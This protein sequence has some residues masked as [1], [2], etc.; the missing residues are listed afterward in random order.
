M[1]ELIN[2]HTN[3]HIVLPTPDNKICKILIKDNTA[4]PIDWSSV[5]LPKVNYTNKL[6]SDNLVSLRPMTYYKGKAFHLNYKY[7]FWGR[8]RWLLNKIKIIFTK[9]INKK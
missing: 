8:L 3:E 1:V 2:K 7:G 9:K 5:E 6:I 4:T